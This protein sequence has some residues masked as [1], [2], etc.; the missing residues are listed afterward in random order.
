MSTLALV[1][2]VRRLTKRRYH[3]TTSSFAALATQSSMLS[4]S[5]SALFDKDHPSMA[6]KGTHGMLFKELKPEQLSAMRAKLGLKEWEDP[7]LPQNDAK[8]AA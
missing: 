4:Q 2:G 7:V 6:G 8:E 5:A 3:D 1:S